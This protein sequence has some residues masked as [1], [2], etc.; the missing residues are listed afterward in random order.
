MD[1]VYGRA[2]TRRL[3][4]TLFDLRKEHVCVKFKYF[5][6]LCMHMSAND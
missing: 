4:A 3:D 6:A 2:E 1:I 5:T